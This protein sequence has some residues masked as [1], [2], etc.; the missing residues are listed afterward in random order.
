MKEQILIS[1]IPKNN[2]TNYKLFIVLDKHYL[3]YGIYETNSAQWYYLKIV[4]AREKQITNLD[5][6]NI[7]YDISSYDY[8]KV[9]LILDTDKYCI[10]PQE[11]YKDDI[12]EKYFTHFVT[13][14]S[15]E[16][17][18]KIKSNERYWIFSIQ[19]NLH[20]QLQLFNPIHIIPLSNILQLSFEKIINNEDSYLYIHVADKQFYMI[21][22][23]ENKKLLLNK[24]FPLEASVD[25]L[26]AISQ[27]KI[28]TKNTYYYMSGYGDFTE[29]IYML[30]SQYF[31]VEILQSKNFEKNTTSFFHL[32]AISSIC[33]S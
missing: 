30:L 3:H 6:E 5:I 9:H 4:H 26:Y 23:D 17:L 16:I 22:Y 18:M 2:D 28:S 21:Q 19:K 13:L 8:K 31:S 15:N 32:Q 24:R 10:V 33:V 1:K 20:K 12:Q 7:I 14:E 27:C 29:E 25:V 11:L